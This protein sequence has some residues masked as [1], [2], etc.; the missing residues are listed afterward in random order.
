MFISG[1]WIGHEN[2]DSGTLDIPCID[3]GGY[4]LVGY[5]L[6]LFCVS[7]LVNSGGFF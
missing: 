5:W 4:S 2:L 3:L 7:W 1:S 6:F